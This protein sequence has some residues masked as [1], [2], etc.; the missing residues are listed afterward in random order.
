M[1]GP[2]VRLADYLGS[3]SPI[4]VHNWQRSRALD[5]LRQRIETR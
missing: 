3:P 4:G 5:G 2:L 1:H